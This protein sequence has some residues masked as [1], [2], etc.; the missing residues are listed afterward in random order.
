MKLIKK[1]KKKWPALKLQVRY[2]WQNKRSTTSVVDSSTNG[3]HVSVTSYG[4]RIKKLYLTLE[5]ICSQSV[6]PAT[7]TVYLSREDIS[8]GHLPVQLQRLKSRGVEFHFED[9]NLRSYKK[10]YYS[11]KRFKV[12][13]EADVKLISIDDDVYYHET[14]LKGLLDASEQAPN[15]VMCY[16]G[17]AISLNSDLSIQ[18]YANWKPENNKRKEIMVDKLLMPTGIAGVLYPIKALKGLDN[19][20]SE[21]MSRCG[22]AD[23]IWFKCLTLS[24]GFG[25]KIVT[26]A[27]NA[28]PRA[29]LTL[30]TKRRGL[31]LFN[32]HQGGNDKQMQ[33]AMEFF[34]T[35]FVDN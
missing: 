2:W 6:R 20:K 5:S 31:A 32:V 7:V 33:S 18:P 23:D 8:D 4:K 25:S 11:Y 3:V 1:I 21:F 28:N 19:Q 24:N 10:L 35:Q 34:N 17:H 30:N 12:E 15:S 26:S 9:E 22:Y 29:Q 27:V 13:T 14:W 16:R